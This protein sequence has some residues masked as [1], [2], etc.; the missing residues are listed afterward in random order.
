MTPIPPIA[1]LIP[2]E[3]PMVWLDKLIEW[4]P[5]YA[6]CQATI[7]THSAGVVDGRQPAVLLLEH[8]AQAVAACL[9]YGAHQ[10]G[11]PVRVGMI[12]ACRTY[13]LYAESIPVGNILTLE[14]KCEREVDEVSTYVCTTYQ[15]QQLVAEAS[16]TLYH[17]SRPP[18]DEHES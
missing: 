2:H 9:G 14:A 12:I 17:A 10:S 1:N 18:D 4:Q 13:E 3:P 6:K 5:G 11:E 16:M 8:M 7:F 15:N